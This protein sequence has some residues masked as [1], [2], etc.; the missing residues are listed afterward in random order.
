MSTKVIL[1]HAK[2]GK[3]RKLP[4]C[5]CTG[6]YILITDKTDYFLLVC[7]DNGDFVDV[8]TG[9]RF[10]EEEIETEYFFDRVVSEVKISYE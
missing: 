10:F 2:N 4:E 9:N 1:E 7:T 8:F 5:I 3:D 6:D